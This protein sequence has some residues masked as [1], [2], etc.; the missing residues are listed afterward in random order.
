MFQRIL[1]IGSDEASKWERV[2]TNPLI[3]IDKIR[4]FFSSRMNN[5]NCLK[6]PE[7]SPVVLIRAW[8]FIEGFTPKEV[9]DQIFDTE[10]R[11]KWE[12][13]TMSLSV[14]ENINETSQV[15]YFYVKV[16]FQQ[17]KFIF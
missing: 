14:V 6:Q 1:S 13:V 11:A 10:K 17:K 3:K 2:V 7:G 8:A 12:T 9:F 15:I 4:V 5:I 16:I